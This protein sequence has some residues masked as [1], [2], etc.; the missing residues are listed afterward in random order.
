MWVFF[1]FLTP[2]APNIL[3]SEVSPNPLDTPNVLPNFFNMLFDFF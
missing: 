1:L 2:N 3:F